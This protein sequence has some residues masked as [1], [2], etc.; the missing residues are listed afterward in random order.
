MSSPAVP[1]MC[2]RIERDQH[3]GP[4]RRADAVQAHA[5][6]VQVRRV[7]AA[8]DAAATRAQLVHA[9]DC[10]QLRVLEPAQVGTVSDAPRAMFDALVDHVE[11]RGAAAHHQHLSPTTTIT[12]GDDSWRAFG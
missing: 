5:G 9:A 11:G 10:C 7:Q 6:K 4:G 8:E 2:D 1:R 12:S 3:V